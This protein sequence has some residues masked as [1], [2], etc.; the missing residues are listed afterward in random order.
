[1]TKKIALLGDSQ[2]QGLATPLRSQLVAAGWPA[3]RS[4]AWVGDPSATTRELIAQLPGIVRAGA[5]DV[6][7][8]TAGGNDRRT[9]EGQRTIW[10][11]LVSRAK[12]SGIGHIVWVAPPRAMD[13]GSDLDLERRRIADAL[14]ETFAGDPQV[15]VVRGRELTQDIPLANSVHFG[16]DGYRRFAERLVP[17]LSPFQNAV[18]DVIERRTP[19]SD[20]SGG[21]ATLS[22]GGGAG[23]L[24]LAAAAGLGAYFLARA[25]RGGVAGLGK[26]EPEELAARKAKRDENRFQEKLRVARA[27]I[28]SPE[29]AKARIDSRF[30]PGTLP[31]TLPRHIRPYANFMESLRGRTPSRRDVIKA[32]VIARSSVQRGAALKS[33]VC[34]YY[35]EYLPLKRAIELES[36]PVE[37]RLAEGCIRK[38]KDGKY[39]FTGKTKDGKFRSRCLDA[40]VRPEDVFG[41]ILFS[42]QGQRYLAAAER[43]E[44]DAEAAREITNRTKCFGLD[45]TLFQDMKYAA[46]Q[47]SPRHKEFVAHLKN[48]SPRQ[49]IEYVQKDVYRLSGAKAGFIAALLGRGDVPTFDARELDLW[50][51]TPSEKADVADVLAYRDAIRQFPM[52]LEPQH[53]PFREHLVHHALWDAYPK[54][55]EPQTRTTHGSVIRSMQ[56]AGIKGRRR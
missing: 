55:S 35:P 26:M 22:G 31:D 14:V 29:V 7:V 28:V 10:R 6:L 25:S 53:E 18:T 27:A 9:T 4:D 17:L 46:E 50:K 56:F 47:L 8:V 51:E 40:S 42:S 19:T 13:A 37:Q 38:K 5:I 30:G 39:R 11:E 32:Y 45:D 44:F 33:A 21:G 20:S 41:V 12:T 16:R 52:K 2:A 1:M 23:L 24:L 36:L 34:N 54:E 3:P 15:T 48:D 43:G 49:W